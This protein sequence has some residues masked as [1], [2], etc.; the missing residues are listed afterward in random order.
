M[1]DN[2]SEFVQCHACGTVA[3]RHELLTDPEDTV[4]YCPIC[5]AIIERED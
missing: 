5:K 1:P 2:T 4:D 3:H